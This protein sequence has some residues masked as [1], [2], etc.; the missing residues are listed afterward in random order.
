MGKRDRSVVLTPAT[1]EQR[2]ASRSGR[3]RS[4][5]HKRGHR[6]VRRVRRSLHKHSGTSKRRVAAVAEG[7]QR[8]RRIDK[9]AADAN[10]S[11]PGTGQGL[12]HLYLRRLTAAMKVP[13][14]ATVRKKTRGRGDLLS[15]L[16]G[17]DHFRWR[18]MRR[19]RC[20]A[21]ACQLKQRRMDL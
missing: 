16:K 8:S 17:S 10:R 7:E 3:H 20:Q 15:A 9:G 21:Q 11:M 1:N 5:S 14:T 18:S 12:Q 6:R 2:A 4:R 13:T 19:R